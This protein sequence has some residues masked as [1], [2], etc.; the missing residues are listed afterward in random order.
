MLKALALKG[1]NSLRGIDQVVICCALSGLGIVLFRGPRAARLLVELANRLPWA[2]MWLP[3]QGED[4]CKTTSSGAYCVNPTLAC[5]SISVP[6]EP[7]RVLRRVSNEAGVFV[8]LV[9]FL[10]G[11]EHAVSDRRFALTGIHRCS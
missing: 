11:L 1:R 6:Q 8:V 4:L 5:V 3:L 2:D 7:T 10:E 9:A